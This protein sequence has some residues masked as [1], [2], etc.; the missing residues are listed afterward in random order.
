[1]QRAGINTHQE[2]GILKNIGVFFARG[3]SVDYVTE[4]QRVKI[5]SISLQTAVTC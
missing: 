1:M 2:I 3:H 4:W 5:C